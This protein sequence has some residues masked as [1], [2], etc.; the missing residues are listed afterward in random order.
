MLPSTVKFASHEKD[1]RRRRRQHPG[2]RYER[3]L[4]GRPRL[5]D[6]PRHGPPRRRCLEW[7]LEEME[8]RR[9]PLV[10]YLDIEVDDTKEIAEK[11]EI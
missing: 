6:R 1:G 11:I 2:L 3:H 10:R 5:V 4:L 7:R 8:N 9:P